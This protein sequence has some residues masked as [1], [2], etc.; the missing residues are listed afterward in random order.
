MKCPQ[1]HMDQHPN[2]RFCSDCG[3]QL[4]LICP[5]CGS[6]VSAKKMFC[7]EC[8]RKLEDN[9]LPERAE[10]SIDSELKQ[11][12]VLFSDMSGYT[13]MSEK[14]NPEDLREITSQVFGEI[15]QTVADHGGIIE[16]FIGDAVVAIFGLPNA[17]EDDPVRAIKAARQIHKRVAAI[18]P[19][20]EEKINMSLSMHTGINTGVVVT[21]EL[22]LG[23]GK[24]GVSGDTI[25]VAARL[26][27]LAK[28]GEIFVGPETYRLSEGHYNFEIQKPTK[29]KGKT[30]PIRLWKVLS[31]KEWPVTLHRHSGLRAELIGRK[32]ELAQLQETILRLKNGKGAILA[33][34]SDAGTGKSRLI[35]ELKASLDPKEI[36][37]VEGH[38][39]PYS[40]NIPYFPLIDLLNRSW[41]VEERDPPER[42]RKKID[43]NIRK[44]IGENEHIVSCIGN[45]YALSSPGIDEMSPESWKYSLRK[46]LQMILSAL[47]KKA[48]TVICLE[49]IHW[50]DPSSI[51]LLQS[52]L[53]EVQGPIL[54]ICIYRPPFR[55]FSGEHS[56]RII[57]RY[58]EI[59]LWDL[60]PP[61]VEHMLESLLKTRMIPHE[62]RRFI[63][64]KVE[65]NPFYL[66]EV[67]NALID[68]GTLTPD[69]GGWLLKRPIIDSDIPATI[70]GVITARLDRLEKE[71][72]RILQ[73]ASV[74]GR[75]FLYK[76]L[77][78]ITE[79]GEDIDRCLSGLERIDLI[80]SKSLQPDLEYIF[81]HA[82]T[83]EVVYNGLLKKERREIHERIAMVVEQL[84]KDRLP[85]FYETLAFHFEKG[86]SFHKAISYLV[87]SGEKSLNK[88][89][90][91]EAH[92]HFQKAFGMLADKSGKTE[93]EEE[94]LIDL[95]LKW[96]FVFHYRGDFRGL[97][98]L[99]T[100][101]ENLVKDLGNQ[102]KLGMYY[103]LLGLA[104]YQTGK[105]K[106]SYQYLRNALKIGEEIDD[107]MVI[108]YACTWLVWN[109]PELGLFEEAL[110]FGKR[111]K[112]ISTQSGADAYLFFNSL[113]GMGLAHWYLGEKK[114][115]LE[116]GQ[117]L[118]DYSHANANIRGL[119]LGH[120][121]IGCGYLIDGDT[122]LAG[123]S[124]KRAVEA[125]VDP[126]YTQFPK[127]LLAFTYIL[128]E[129]FPEAEDALEEVLSH[130]RQFGTE[131]IQT[132]ALT[133]RG[134][135]LIAKGQLSKGLR[136]IENAQQEDLRKGRKYAVAIEELF[137]GK[138]YQQ[139]SAGGQINFS[140]VRNIG[141][142]AKN[143]P[144]AGRKAEEHFTRSILSAK[145]I[146][147]KSILGQACLDLGILYKA[148][149][150]PDIARKYISEAIAVLRQCNATT[151]LRQANET[152]ET[153]G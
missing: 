76:I 61:E 123:E 73:E 46:A 49:D 7:G 43:V 44:L 151:F 19:R 62:L 42:V 65:G 6:R 143:I 29:V 21:G 40:Q 93:L 9:E 122:H 117:A 71:A 51:E 100:A 110:C 11:I 150:K 120:F 105:V 124:F 72:K 121:A 8:G 131:I 87:K 85:E 54:F 10:P 18:S 39:F 127:M 140:M 86:R 58:Q 41:Q 79:C 75:A 26:S 98:R 91:E 69:N 50:A 88:Y 22:D 81:K 109:C 56:S 104:L 12:S 116:I 83:H 74:I 145:E 108:G 57:E 90:V 111:A 16:K 134:I 5:Q 137:L 68:S 147:A 24:H 67:I 92:Q 115:T 17:H 133:M 118:L 52:I 114:N 38:A 138:I 45:L 141:F 135:L 20:L 97:Q 130:S 32:S 153:L 102:S 82:L 80:R 3:T 95:L 149:G 25:N 1:C 96:A 146:G 35:E 27:S 148:K 103:A 36:Q 84:F 107:P 139:I 59:K 15:A 55:L 47:T 144:V 53:S 77:A 132:P 30:K 152:I 89:A 31:A 129:K 34:C 60:K 128:N 112:K 66:E 125:S 142:L 33:L 13:S 2:N 23:K 113:G 28:P 136:M 126:W 78:R 37:W 101:H 48:P 94:L 63:R 106:E 119:V 99:L 14:L 4:I 70:Q 64:E